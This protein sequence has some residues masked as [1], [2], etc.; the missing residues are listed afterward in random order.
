MK[1]GGKRQGRRSSY[2][3]LARP[4]ILKNGANTGEED[5]NQVL[6]RYCL[7]SA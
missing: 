2:W 5:T 4:S 3:Q 1:L 6:E 7:D